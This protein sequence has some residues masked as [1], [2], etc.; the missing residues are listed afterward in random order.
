M[1]LVSLTKEQLDPEQLELYKQI[2][3]GSRASPG[4]SI[5]LWSTVAGR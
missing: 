5:L 4:H 2:V 1:R 3:W